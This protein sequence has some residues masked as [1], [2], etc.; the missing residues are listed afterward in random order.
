[1]PEKAAG[2]GGF[3]LEVPVDASAISA[4]DLKQ[5][6]LKIVVRSCEGEL[7]SEPVKLRGDGSG[8][9]RFSFAK[10]PGS[11]R[12][13]IGPD[14]AQD[15]ELA[16]S[17]TIA[18]VVPA[19][20]LA[21]KRQLVLEPIV[22]SYWWWWWWLRWCRE[23]TIHG[24]VVCP[25]G[26]PV[27]GAEVC[28]YDVD[29]FWWW[30]SKQQVGCA[31]T[32]VNGSFDIT[33]RW[34]CG[35]WPWWWW[36]YRAW[37]FQPELAEAI[38]PV[39]ERDPRIELGNATNVPSLEV[40]KP[41]LAG[42]GLDL[43][44]PLAS[45]P[46]AS[47]DQIRSSLIEKLPKAPELG[48][49][50][51]WPWWPWWPWWDCTP[52]IIFKVT[53]DC[54]L[55]GTVIVDEG[56]GATRWDIPDPLNVTLVANSL[57]CCKPT[58]PCIEG[59]CIDISAFCSEEYLALDD[60]GGNPGAPVGRPDG[61]APGDR[62]FSETVAVL[63]ANTFVGVDYYEIEFWDTGLGAWGPVPAGACE[64]FCRHWLQPIFPFPS[65]NVAFKWTVRNDAAL[66]P[67]LVVESREHH[68]TV[69]PL[70]LAA[71]WE[72]SSQLVVPLNSRVFADGTY[73]FRVVGWQDAGG[74]TIKNGHVLKV[75]ETDT[76]NQW[77]L[78]FDNRVY[79]DPTVLNC[80]SPSVRLCTKEPRA[81]LT[82]ITIDG[83]PIPACGVSE[84]NGNLVVDFEASDVDGHLESYALSI[85]WGAGLVADLLTLPG[86]TLARVTGDGEGPS[87][88]AALGQ[89]WGAAVPTWH[90]GTMRLTVSAAEAF[91]EPC[92][93]LIRLEAWKRHVLGTAFGACGY[94]C[95]LDQYYNI[96]E[97]TVGAGVCDPR[98]EIA[99]AAIPEVG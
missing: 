14:R 65:G 58:P 53:Q 26:R 57:A 85:H 78:T 12:V 74:G 29:W 99:V 61:Y 86:A 59:D 83:S 30:W 46:A 56:Y 49:L 70:P 35:F 93:Y 7:F 41:L 13:L 28:A 82:S 11:V 63:K 24:H 60:V 55:P 4:D 1:M 94:T 17:Q 87:Y 95:D 76:D 50:R 37:E 81:V 15:H 25:D 89:G 92:C 2:S 8:S 75:C 10:S 45:V 31:F 40:F 43:S 48:Q 23:F 97:F 16:D 91:P 88:A 84:I 80:G 32:D 3:T 62:P 69:S 52:D 96:D 72:I 38:V 18:V 42:R 98:P 64:D 66:K 54:H 79:P 71:F 33:F 36:R 51:I 47:L 90:G 9:A 77:I 22:V 67:H 73:T 39:L 27:P 5:Q 20:R 44:K 19:S 21:A 68:E 6:N 34:C